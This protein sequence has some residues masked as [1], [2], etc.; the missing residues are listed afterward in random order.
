MFEIF[1]KTMQDLI[2]SGKIRLWNNYNYFKEL[3]TFPQ[4]P[5]DEKEHITKITEHGLMVKFCCLLY[6]LSF[7]KLSTTDKEVYI[8]S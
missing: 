8:R 5:K 4:K 6:T 7:S 1:F 3:Y 2:L